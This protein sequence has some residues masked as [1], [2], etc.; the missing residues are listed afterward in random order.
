MRTATALAAFVLLGGAVAAQQRDVR[1]LTAALSAT[2]PSTRARAACDLREL[3]SD[4]APAVPAL[5]ALLSDAT[6]VEATACGRGL[7][8][9]WGN[10]ETLT[11][12]GELAAAALAAIGTP[13]FDPAIKALAGA[14]WV[15]RR[16][17][18]WL[19]GVLD[20]SRAARALMDALRDDEPRVRE[21]AAW[22]LG[23]L[24]HRPAI[25]PLIAALKDPDPRVRRQAAWALGVI[26]G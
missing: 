2:E 8:R 10:P 19:L 20:D 5:V 15:T 21:Q 17:A 25:E 22:A 12:P 9:R 1:D 24:D 4:A 7:W 18:A 6:P 13:A 14:S 11:T 3:G 26:G 23:V 16:N